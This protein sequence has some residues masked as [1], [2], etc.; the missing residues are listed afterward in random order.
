MQESSGTTSAA[1]LRL[2]W[3]AFLAAPVV[4]VVLSSF[5]VRGGEA[6][7]LPMPLTAV[8]ALAAA[9]TAVAG[10]VVPDLVARQRRGDATRSV[11][12]LDLYQTAMI[13]RWACFEAI[14][15]YGFVLA[16]ASRQLVTVVVGAM[17]SVA[18]IAGSRP[19]PDRAGGQG[20]P[21]R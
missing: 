14:A 8:L 6:L 11:S 20:G 15:I 7:P 9:A 3:I 19:Q 17:V 12:P 4:Y 13:V 1:T 18:L 5:V 2:I 10:H 16:I 21:S